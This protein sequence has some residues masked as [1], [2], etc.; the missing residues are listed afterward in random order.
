MPLSIKTS[1]LG[2]VEKGS[3]MRNILVGSVL[4]LCSLTGCGS[5]GG[6]FKPTYF[7]SSNYPYAILY[8]GNGAEELAGPDW[9][10]DNFRQVRSKLVEKGGDKYLVSRAYDLNDD[11][12]VDVNK[13]EHF[14]DVLLEHRTKDA[15]LWVRA[16]PLSV[17]DD[18]KELNV[19]AERYVDSASGT[20]QIAVHFGSEVTV[21]VGKR[22]ASRTVGV[23]NCRVAGKPALVV[24]FEVAN[25]DQ[26]E[27]SESARWSRG[28]VAF[29]KPGY[30]YPVAV[31][32][33]VTKYPVLLLVGLSS[34][35]SEFGALAPHFDALL[36]R[37][38]LGVKGDVSSAPTVKAKTGHT[39]QVPDV[40][41]PSTSGG[42][43]PSI[44]AEK[45]TSPELPP[46]PSDAPPPASTPAD[47]APE[48]TEPKPAS[49]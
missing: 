34:T 17:S 21:S 20:G 5:K 6:T 48:S 1:Y 37:I 43:S 26:L 23:S 28:R 22:F 40:Q 32:T 30:Y 39:C 14:Y 27:L 16:V 13:E 19:F 36:G 46:P 3:H 24:D 41:P 47:Q 10:I 44:P 42:E 7:Q 8:Q 31:G 18:R 33:R 25:V 49:P 4:A 9:R 35:P 2:A 15:S 38:A 12:K 29:I 11:G 45:S